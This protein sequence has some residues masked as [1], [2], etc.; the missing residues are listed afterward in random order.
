MPPVAVK[1]TTGVTPALALD[2]LPLTPPTLAVTVKVYEV[3]LLN[4]VT[5]NGEELPLAVKF[6]GDDVAVYETVPPLPAYAGTVNETVACPFPALADTDVGTPGT[7]P[8]CEALDPRIGIL[9][10][11]YLFKH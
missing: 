8:D 3:P 7:L 11:S 9:L 4:P 6:P 5:V 1:G 2:A 10:A